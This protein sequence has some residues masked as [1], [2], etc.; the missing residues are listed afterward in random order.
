ML[1]FLIL[2]APIAFFLLVAIMPAPADQG[3]A[4][5]TLAPF[6]AALSGPTLQGLLDSLGLSVST[7]ILSL[8]VALV[9][10][11]LVQR[12][13]LRG[14]PAWNLLVWVVLLTPSFL[15][16]LGWERLL[17]PEGVLADLGWPVSGLSHAFFSPLGVIFV[18]T[19]KGVPFAFLAIAAALGA[20]GREYEDAVR[21]HGGGRA[22]AM[23]MV[24]PILAPALWSALAIVFAETI[25]DFGVASTIANTSNFPVATMTLFNAVDNFPV[26][27]PVAAAVGWL[28]V[29]SIG[30]ALYA[31]S[32]A[33]RGR[34]YQ[35]LSG[36]SRT[37][38]RIQLSRRG[39]LA[40]VSIMVLFFGLTL[41]VPAIAVASASLL[42]P[43]ASAITLNSLTLSNYFD[44]ARHPS[45]LGPIGLS[46]ALALIATSLAVALGL[47]VARIL[48]RRRSGVQA[49]ILDLL[50]LATVGLPGILLGA[51]YI[52]V[53]NLPALATVGLRLYGTLFLL[54]VAYLANSL[55]I[56]ARLLSGPMAQIQFGLHDA[57]RV[58]GRNALGAWR[59]TVVPLLSRTLIWAWLFGFTGILF[60]L[61][62]SQLL[63]PPGQE[64][65]S[66][67]ITAAFANFSYAPGTTL[68]V[69]SVAYALAVVGLVLVGFRVFAPKGWQRV[70]VAR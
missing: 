6:I 27:F 63:Y 30:L 46:T 31:Q 56:T 21:I 29:A 41:G 13:N 38:A 53:Y 52:F 5:F 1:F 58:H 32:R 25:S 16:A 66:V 55:P 47:I 61:P 69:T 4:W 68:M 18:D 20:L 36:R 50:L 59:T 2:L 62:V 3:T 33:L 35:V 22:T 24:L 65:L 40:G 8:A 54:D 42:K 49:R 44:L 48:T 12:T 45:T 70:G 28:L 26:N 7:A 14:R 9:L 19:T 10:A 37:S 11:W 15:V 34:S 57:A 43:A 23:R 64:P 39:Q 17:Q 67:A 60:E 51:G